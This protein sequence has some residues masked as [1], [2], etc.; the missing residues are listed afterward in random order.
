MQLEQRIEAFHQLGQVLGSLPEEKLEHWCHAARSEN[1]WFTSENVRL[2]IEGI[3]FFLE[4]DSLKKWTSN[5]SID[6]KEPKTVAII[7]AGNI[8]LVGFH[9]FLCVLLSGHKVMMKLSSKDSKL[10]MLL[11][12]ELYNIEP[13]FKE[14]IKLANGPMKNFDAVIATGSDNSAR[15]FDHYFSKYPNIIRKNRT[16]CAILTGKETAAEMQAL[17]RD[18]FAYFGLGCRNVSKLFVPR[19]YNF[20]TI[21]D[22]WA[23]FSDIIHHHKFNNNYDYQKA[24][25]LVNQHPHLDTHYLLLCE[26]DKLVSPIAVLFYEYYD[27]EDELINTILANRSK[28]QCIVGSEAYCTVAFGQTQQPSV[29]AYADEVDTM[30]F[31]LTL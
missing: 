29:S 6:T 26:S 23:S 8:P 21:L 25:L 31:L 28:L 19:G 4:I 9:D 2:A 27:S 1:A 11:L 20:Q 10:F 15:Y 5:Y 24:I 17:G 16:S 7:L 14:K 18:V 30:A 12:D 13:S 3:S 22:S